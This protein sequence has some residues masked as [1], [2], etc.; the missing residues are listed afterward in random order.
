MHSI[1]TL[2][3]FGTVVM[4]AG[5]FITTLALLKRAWRGRIYALAT[6][7]GMLTFFLIASTSIALTLVFQYSFALAPCL[8]CWWQRVFMYP[9]AFIALIAMVKN[10]HVS[11]IADYVLALSIIGAAIALY[12]HLLQILPANS[13]IPCDASGDCAVRTVFEFGFVTIPWMALSA[14]AAL[15]L[16]AFLARKN[17]TT[18]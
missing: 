16:I 2:I 17:P 18:T 11:E 4:D 6:N 1:I 12:Q 8:L 5:I 14:F 15:I 13:L 7:Y 3:A 10:T 9:T